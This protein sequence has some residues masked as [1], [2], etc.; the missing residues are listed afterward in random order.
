MINYLEKNIQ[1]YGLRSGLPTRPSRKIPK[2]RPMDDQS[3]RKL[4]FDM[5][6][7]KDT[8]IPLFKHLFS[9][10]MYVYM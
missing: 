6:V 4:L 1:K 9:L 3:F 7:T 8:Y 5:E 2:A 10:L